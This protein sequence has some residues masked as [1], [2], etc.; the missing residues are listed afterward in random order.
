MNE[1]P[2]CPRGCASVK[3]VRDGVQRHHG[4]RARQRYR[5]VAPDGSYHRFVGEGE[6]SRTRGH[7]SCDECYRPLAADGGPV[8]PKFGKYLVKE[9]AGALWALADGASYTDAAAR[10]RRQAWGDD[11]AKK[12]A[13]T[14]I[15]SGQSVAEWLSRYGAVVTA[16]HA[17]TQWPRTIVVDSTRFMH[18]DSR[19]GGTNQLFCVL[20][21]W[22]Y[23]AGPDTPRLWRLRA[24]PLQD[25]PTWANFLAE[26]PGRPDL[27]VVDRDYGAIGGVQKHWGTGKSAVPIHLCEHHLYAR[28]KAALKKDGHKAYKHPLQVALA[29]ALA[30]PAG[31]DTFYQLALGAGG[32]SAKWARHW[33]KRMRVQTRRRSSMPAHYAN[34]AVEAPIK[35]VKRVLASRSWTFRNAQRM[36]ALLELVRVRYNGTAS[37]AQ[38][39]TTLRTTLSSG[40]RPTDLVAADARLPGVRVSS[41]SLRAWMPKQAARHKPRYRARAK[42]TIS[43]I[44]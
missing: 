7:G 36:N 14:T 34:G 13:A 8:A 6:L 16:P 2:Q 11:G 42:A 4:G 43:P 33:N 18:N 1:M 44:P 26:L 29:S 23:P 30:T 41:S 25:A 31:W 35:E 39:A 12:R 15:A 24:Y 37:E 20:A 27:V 40:V 10:V 21:A 3:V 9:V 17:E 5:C 19:G 22:G 32:E 28:G 38:F